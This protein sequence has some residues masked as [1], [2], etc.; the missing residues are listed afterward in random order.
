MNAIKLLLHEHKLMKKMVNILA[1]TSERSIAE[2]KKLFSMIKHDAQLHE[3]MEEKFLYPLLKEFKTSRLNAF[4]HKEEVKLM[5]HLLT[6]LSKTDMKSEIWTAK[7]VVLKELNDH[8]IE[9]E[10]D[11]KFVQ[12]KKLLSNE[13]LKEIGEKMIEFKAKHDR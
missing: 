7:F 1:K 6:Q 3:K 11:E 4:E 8:H 2:R 9:E 13:V 12:A 5:E 10:E